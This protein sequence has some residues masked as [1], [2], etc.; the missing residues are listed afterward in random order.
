[1]KWNL[2]AGFYL[3]GGSLRQ[4]LTMFAKIAAYP[5]QP[6]CLS[7][8]NPGITGINHC[9]QLQGSV[10]LHFQ[11]VASTVCLDRPGS[12]GAHELS[13]MRIKQLYTNISLNS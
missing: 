8:Q 10:D 2:G 6:S 13:D 11:K 5:Q 3:F 4:G 12:I 7:H 9:A 1:M